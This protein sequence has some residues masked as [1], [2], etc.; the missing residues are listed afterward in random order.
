MSTLVSCSVGSLVLFPIYNIPLFY[1]V[2]QVVVINEY[3]GNRVNFYS[4]V[5]WMVEGHTHLGKKSHWR[6]HIFCL[7]IPLAQLTQ[8]L[9]NFCRSHFAQ[10]W[11]CHQL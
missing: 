10:Y 9:T 7:T 5:F 8:F 3:L 4:N 6:L 1:L 11:V 2:I